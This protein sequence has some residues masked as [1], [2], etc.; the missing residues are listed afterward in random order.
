MKRQDKSAIVVDG[1][2]RLKASAEHHQR[3]RQIREAIRVKYAP[4]L[5]RAGFFRRCVL[6]WRMMMDYR[7]ESRRT[8]P[9]PSSLYLGAFPKTG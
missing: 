1:G 3:L 8:G 7:K 4:E 5:A 6:R 9:S 2:R